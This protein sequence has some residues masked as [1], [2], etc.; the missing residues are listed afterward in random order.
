MENGIKS[1]TWTDQ[2]KSPP[3]SKSA[4]LTRSVLGIGL[5]SLFSDLGHEMA[6]TVLPLFLAQQIAASAFALGL[7]EGLSD[8]LSSYF[9]LVGGWWTDR[10]GKRKPLAVVG[11]LITALSTSSFALARNWGMVLVSRSLAWAARGGRTEARNA[12]MADS[13]EPVHYGRAFGFERSM[14]TAGAVFAPIIALGLVSFGFSYRH[15]FLV[16]LFPGLLA[17]A[18]MAW[19]VKEEARPAQPERHL[20]GDLKQLPVGFRYYVMVVGVFGLGQ[21]AP[22]LLILRASQLLK[23]AAGSGS[24]PETVIALYILFNIIQSASAYL[25][26]SLSHCFGSIQLL[27]ISYFSFALA[28]IGFAF[29]EGRLATLVVLFALAG[30]AVGGIEAMEPTAAAELLP[31][32]HRG[33]GFGALGAANGVGDFLSSATVGGLW[34]A[35]G[36]GFGFGFAAIFNLVSVILLLFFKG[37]FRQ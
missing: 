27:G 18:A 26:G 9:K 2:G 3:R 33:T 20:F 37:S 14:D 28:A 22:T 11:Y 35:F 29:V 12:L 10:S 8:G 23:P 17:V 36:A 32:S 1:G 30:F 5:A 31:A 25:W 21:F 19:L 34:T 4:W 15:V 13:V 24:S 6:T 7:I 16:A